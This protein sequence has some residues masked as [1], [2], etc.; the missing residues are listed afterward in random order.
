[1]NLGLTQKIPFTGGQLSLQSG[2]NR[3]DLMDTKSHYYRAR[4]LSVSLIQPIF[5]INSMLWGT[6]MHRT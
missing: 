2:L 3:I 1:M 4:P 5:Q 6:G